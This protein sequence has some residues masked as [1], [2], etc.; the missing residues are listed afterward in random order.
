MSTT[1][2]FTMKFIPK[3]LI[4]D[5]KYWG[6]FL[7]YFEIQME[8]TKKLWDARSKMEAPMNSKIYF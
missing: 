4:D 6:I 7:G 5:D 8:W 3:P 1:Y 2:V